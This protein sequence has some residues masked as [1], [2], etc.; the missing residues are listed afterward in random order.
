MACLAAPWLCVFGFA[1]MF[2]DLSINLSKEDDLQENKRQR[3]DSARL[4]CE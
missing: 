4:R 3:F 1:S 2:T